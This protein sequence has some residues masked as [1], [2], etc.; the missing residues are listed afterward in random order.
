MTA[1]D[2]RSVELSIDQALRVFEHTTQPLSDFER[3][4]HQQLQ[5][6]QAELHQLA[7]KQAAKGNH[8]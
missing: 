3:T 8:A 6:L 4:A 1:G 7:A 2:Y 5:E